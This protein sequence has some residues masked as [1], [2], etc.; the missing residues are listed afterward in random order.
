MVSKNYVKIVS[1]CKKNVSVAG[2]K[3]YNFVILNL[4][5]FFEYGRGYAV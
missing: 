1:G 3:C 2:G 4:A 5:G